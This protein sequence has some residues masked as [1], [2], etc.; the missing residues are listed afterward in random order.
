[1]SNVSKLILRVPCV[2]E[3]SAEGRLAVTVLFVLAVM[4]ILIVGLL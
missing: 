3:A 1:M 2:I 4:I